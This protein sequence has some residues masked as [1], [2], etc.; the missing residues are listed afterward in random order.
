MLKNVAR[1]QLNG[2]SVAGKGT[3]RM[4][5]KSASSAPVSPDG[6]NCLPS[7][8]GR[9]WSGNGP[10]HVRS[11]QAL[12]VAVQAK[13]GNPLMPCHPARARELIRKG[14]AVR[15]FS[16]G[17]FYIRLTTRD[18][19]DVQPVALG[20]DPGSK[21]EGYTIKSEKRTFLNI[22]AKALDWVKQAV[23]VRRNMRRARRFRKTP[24]RANRQNRSRGALPP[25]TRAR[26]QWKLRVC[27]WLSH[28]YPISVFVVEDVK[29]KKKGKRRWDASF[30][31]LEVGKRWFYEELSNLS[32]IQT[33][34][35]WEAKAMRDRLGLAKIGRKAAE[36]FEAHCV[37]SWVLA[38]S[39]VGGTVPDNRR[40]MLIT[41][42]RF[43]RRQ[44]HRLQPEKGSIRRP[45]GGTRSLGFKRGSLVKHPKYGVCFVGGTM[46][47]RISLH[48]LADGKRLCQNAKPLECKFL[49]FNTWRTRLLP[50]LKSGV[51]AA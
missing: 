18:V 26:W 37:D 51:S 12:F 16:K 46:R 4:L 29:A 22:Q 10:S 21:R 44:I 39:A 17:I 2:L 14:M 3:K 50:A 34:S 28:L 49:A 48:S 36:V 31:P 9:D 41:P 6:G 15:R 40:L 45:Y 1:R 43:Y 24:C 35:G 25:S 32:P 20:I 38:A 23:E 5:P 33:K 7:K 47:D 13:N 30:S 8:G 42:L 19:G 27:R 11:R